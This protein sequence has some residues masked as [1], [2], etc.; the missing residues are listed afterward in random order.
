MGIAISFIEE[1]VVLVQQRL[2]DY[3]SLRE[4]MEKSD[5]VDFEAARFLDMLD[6]YF[7]TDRGFHFR[8]SISPMRQT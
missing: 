4:K 3:R 5:F 1:L 2:A 6:D 8:L 7:M